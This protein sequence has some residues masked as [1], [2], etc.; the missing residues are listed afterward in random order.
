MIVGKNGSFSFFAEV[1]NKSFKPYYGGIRVNDGLE[2]YTILGG[3]RPG[4]T[5][6]A[7]INVSWILSR[8]WSSFNIPIVV[9]PE[10]FIPESNETNNMKGPYL[11]TIY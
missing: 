2:A 9:D 8:G 4:E 6:I 10:N 7:E 3:L 11:I 5:K 1:M